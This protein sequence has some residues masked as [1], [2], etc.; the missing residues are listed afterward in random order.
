MQLMN[1]RNAKLCPPDVSGLLAVFQ[2]KMARSSRENCKIA[3][4]SI[5]IHNIDVNARYYCKSA[6]AAPS[7]EGKHRENPQSGPP[8]WRMVIQRSRDE[9]A[10]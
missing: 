10:L 3:T 1:W 2:L 6:G 8:T 9:T 4:L 5:L 7:L